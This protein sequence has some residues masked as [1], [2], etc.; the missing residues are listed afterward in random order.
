MYMDS[1]TNTSNEFSPEGN[2]LAQRIN[3]FFLGAGSAAAGTPE[4]K[5]GER[6][7]NNIVREFT[8]LTVNGLVYCKK[9]LNDNGKQVLTMYFEKYY[10]RELKKKLRTERR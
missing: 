7:W 5:E 4:F 1:S 2:Y 9:A 3:K 8:F 10:D 6:E